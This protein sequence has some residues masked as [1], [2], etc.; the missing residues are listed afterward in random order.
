MSD[1]E[2]NK[3][4]SSATV[5]VLN[6]TKKL[7]GDNE[8]AIKAISTRNAKIKDLEDIINHQDIAFQEI[9]ERYDDIAKKKAYAELDRNKISHDYENVYAN[10]KRISDELKVLK[11]D[12]S[13]LE[14]DHKIMIAIR[15]RTFHRKIEIYAEKDGGRKGALVKLLFTPPVSK[16]ILL[17]IFVLLF[18]ASIVGW[19]PVV[20]ALKPIG[21]IF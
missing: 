10:W 17:I 5:N 11:D 9:E 8:Y 2:Y 15:D 18:V 19:S 3:N 16:I 14:K 20:A 4:I 7:L 12:Y 6:A 1:D 13:K 21:D